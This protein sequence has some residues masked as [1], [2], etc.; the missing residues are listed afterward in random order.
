MFPLRCKRA[1][2]QMH[3]E[4]K[5]RAKRIKNICAIALALGCNRAH[6]AAGL[7]GERP[8]S[9]KLLARYHAIT[10]AQQKSTRPEHQTNS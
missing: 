5:K 4:T 10:R 2:C 3:N 1:L 6:L 7:R 9:K 8:I